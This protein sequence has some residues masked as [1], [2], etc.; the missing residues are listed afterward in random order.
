MRSIFATVLCLTYTAIVISCG[1][2]ASASIHLSTE[3]T[4]FI[5]A[6]ISYPAL[7]VLFV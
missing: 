3:T 5:T 4:Q 2:V 7:F 6:V 1:V